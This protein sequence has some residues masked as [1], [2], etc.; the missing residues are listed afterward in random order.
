MGAAGLCDVLGA[1]KIE[2]ALGWPD[3]PVAARWLAR[4]R[5]IGYAFHPGAWGR[6]YAL[7]SAVAA[8]DWAFDALGWN[9]IIHCIAPANAASR[10]VAQ[11]LGSRMIRV[12][13]LLPPPA[14]E[15][16]VELWGQSRQHW[17]ANRIRFA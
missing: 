8:I 4:Q 12:G 14:D 10:K 15:V 3:G 17:R 7:E 5:E 9:E 6:G 16:E 13:R 2:R 1:G 11:R